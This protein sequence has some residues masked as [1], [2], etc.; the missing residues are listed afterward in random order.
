[1]LDATPIDVNAG[2]TVNVK[3]MNSALR[4]QSCLVLLVAGCSPVTA[5]PPADRDEIRQLDPAP[6]ARAGAKIC[7]NASLLTGPSS[8][9]KG[10]IVVPKGDNSSLVPAPNK[11]YWFAGG[12][13]TFGGSAYGQIIAA[14]GDVFIGAPHAILD[15]RLK[16]QYAF[17]GNAST[18]TIEYLTI[19]RFGA[20][21][22]NNGQGVVN[23]NSGKHWLIQYTT[24]IDDAGAGVFLGPDSTT[25]YN[26]LSH[27]GEYGFASYAAHGD[28]EVVLDHNEIVG[29]NTYDWERHVYGCGCSGGGKFW[30]TNGGT[31]TNNWV[32]D[33]RGP[34]LWADTDNNDFDFENNDI[35]NNTAEGII[36]EI[37]YNALIRNNTFV[38][39]ALVAGPKN[40]GFPTGAIYLSESGGDSRVAARYTT[41]SVEKNT[42]VDNWSG[43]VLFENADRFCGSPANSSS[44]FCTLVDPKVANLKTCV[45]GKIRNEPYFSDCRWKTQNVSVSGNRFTFDASHIAGCKPSASCGLQGLFSNWGTFPKWSPYKGPLVEKAI[46]FHQDD[47]FSNNAYTGPWEFMAHDQSRVLTFAQWHRRPYRQDRGSTYQ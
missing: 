28:R 24:V 3:H 13:H 43:V 27:N 33:N 7:G 1:M 47:S 17:T 35:E 44:K 15:G 18:V 4:V 30:V 26:C 40:P 19:R 20:V 39:N 16:N 32:H 42:F 10:A 22:S 46:T 12:T 8:P 11:T 41:I 36:I 38:R 2:R 14:D 9:P 45:R 5:T 23:H 25:R 29:N 6:A 37:S 34:A 31:V 21:G